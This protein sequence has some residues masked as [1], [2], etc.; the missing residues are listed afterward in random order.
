MGSINNSND[1]NEIFRREYSKL[2]AIT[3]KLFG[4]HQIELAEDAVQDTLVAALQYW[5]IHGVP[6]NPTA[7]LIK[8]ARN[9][10]IDIIRKRQ[11]QI[12]FD[13]SISNLLHSEYTLSTTVQEIIS[14]KHIADDQLRMM[15][16][17]CHPALNAESQLCII[18]QTLCGFSIHEIAKALV[19]SY[20]AIEK[21]LYRAR[22]IWRDQ[23]ISLEWPDDATI[24]ARLQS[25]ITA[26]YLL[27][28]EGYHSTQEDSL[29]RPDLLLEARRLLTLLV[30]HSSTNLPEVHALMA[31]ICFMHARYPSRIDENGSFINL[32]EQD[33]SKWNVT[34]IAAGN[35][36][37]DQAMHTEHITRY[38]LEAM[39]AQIHANASTYGKTDWNSICTLYDL[40]IKITPTDTV[41]INRA[42]ALSEKGE[43]QKAYDELKKI[44][45]TSNTYVVDAAIADVCVKL[46]RYED[47]EKYY[48]QAAE[49]T[50]SM[51]ERDYFL[52]KVKS[53]W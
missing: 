7:W 39:I 42:I 4:P 50:K 10:S 46:L 30:S 34:W 33:R 2:L 17:C 28:N 9:K 40:L 5:K 43:V 49:K 37:L 36:A 44:E 45:I 1:T 15:F 14:D 38:H 41:G 31:M 6:Q 48:L 53:L 22:K 29:S 3:L 11:R 12:H 21:K 26:I 23:N 8:V 18:L 35:E 51:V 19:S 20:D 32:R 25:V 13:A 27:A 52:K 16:V 47:A 24:P